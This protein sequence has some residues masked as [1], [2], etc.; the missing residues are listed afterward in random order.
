MAGPAWADGSDRACL[1]ARRGSETALLP[2]WW[3]QAL[4]AL[5]AATAREGQPWSCPDARVSVIPPSHRGPALLE[6]E[7]ATGVRRR[8]VS[9][10]ADVV[11]LGE[12]M[13]ARTF[14]LEAP[15]GHVASYRLDPWTLGLPPPPLPDTL[16]PAPPVALGAAKPNPNVLVDLLV[17]SRVTGP[18][19]AVLL[20]A[21]LRTALV[22]DRWSVGLMA[23]YDSA[24]A[25]LQ[26]VPDQFSL[27]SVSI[28][29]TGGYRLL[30]APVELTVAL[31]PS[32]AV[33]LVSDQRPS[34]AEPDVDTKVDMRLGAR[35]GAAL[36]LTDR[37]R[38]VCAL[39]GEGAPEA[40]FTDRHSRRREL[41][42]L[43]AYMAGLSCGV[44][45]VA[46]R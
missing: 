8:P 35:L 34:E 12:A 17:G 21:E 3:Q 15:P 29:L 25:Y 11:P 44:E 41:P 20:G 37:L 42:S 22:F 10:P 43:P 23:R 16:A 1:P 27:A 4:D 40:L 7:D 28:G 9:S 14:T 36:P 46:I 24:I 45:L 30:A 13:L 38:G 26:P 18:T 31:E 2:V 33:L 5:I 32:L 39:G 6:V 19:L